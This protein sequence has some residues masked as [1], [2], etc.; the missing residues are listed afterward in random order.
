MLWTLFHILSILRCN[1]LKP[2]DCIPANLTLKKH[3]LAIFLG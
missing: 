2:F 1:Q 3:T